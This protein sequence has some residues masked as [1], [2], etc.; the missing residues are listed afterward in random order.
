MVAAGAE[1]LCW[2]FQFGDDLS[3]AEEEEEEESK[4]Q[5]SGIF[6]KEDQQKW[7]EYLFFLKFFLAFWAE[8]A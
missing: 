1:Y 2:S 5:M 7:R 4:D 8:K 6:S 3:V